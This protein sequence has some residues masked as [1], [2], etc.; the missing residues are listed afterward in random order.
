MRRLLTIFLIFAAVP[1]ILAQSP[2]QP[3]SGTI[4]YITS[5]NV[6]VRFQTTE[7]IDPG[8]TLF[9]S[10]GDKEIPV[11]IVENLSS[12]SAVCQPISDQE[13]SVNMTLWARKKNI[14]IET[15]PTAEEEIV[16]VP[17]VSETYEDTLKEPE[18][19][20]LQQQ[21]TGRFGISSYTN[22]S[23][24]EADNSQKMRYTAAVAIMNIAGSRLSFDSYISFV[25]SNQNWDR[26]QSNIFNG[27]KIYAFSLNYD[28]NE[29]TRLLLGRK[30]NPKLSSMGA[31][32]GLQ[33]EKKIGSFSIGAVAGSRP[34]YKDYSVNFSLLQGGVYVG[35]EYKQSGKY[36]QSTLA[37]IQQMNS[38]NT[39]RRF[40]YLQHM[41]TLVKNLFFMGT[42]EVDLYKMVDSV[43]S[44]DFK[45]SNLYLSIRYR[46]I[47]QLSFTLSY[48]ARQNIIYYETY[49]NIIDQLNDETLQGFRFQVNASPFRNFSLG[50]TAAYRYRKDD[51]SATRNLY[52]YATYSSVP[53]IRASLTGSFTWLE[54]GYVKGKIYSIGLNKDLVA[55][56]L[57]G[58]LSY[59]Y[60]DYTFANSENALAQNLAEINLMWRIMKKL[61]F[62]VYYEGT[63]ESINHYHRIYINLTQR[64]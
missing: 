35:H 42:A 17:A 46:V 32:D 57:S 53:F 26:I 24:T 33:F 43:K 48:N 60:V 37:F 23:N 49:K 16:P 44:S 5:Q 58:G 8:D 2:V 62:S 7:N 30:I 25:H 40:L 63:F 15:A 38:G 52:A 64:L 20:E 27:L 47:R 22:F 11:L 39:D 1:A 6:Y 28:F 34:D 13:L 4:S 61:S 55:G 36:M 14:A 54:T 10:D 51:P 29:T 31:I 3:E 19:K 9:I 12:I 56:K 45:L 21:L 50:A 59:R 41:N 18:K